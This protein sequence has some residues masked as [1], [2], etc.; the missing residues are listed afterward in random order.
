MMR[1]TLLVAS[2][3]SAF[4]V[5]LADAGLKTPVALDVNVTERWA[6]GSFADTR[7]NPTT[8]QTIGCGL[9]SYPGYTVAYCSAYE[10]YTPETGYQS[11]YCYTTDPAMVDTIKSIANDS[12]IRFQWNGNYGECT[13]IQVESSSNYA[14]KLP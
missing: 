10:G 5:N 12:W 1:R 2:L 4:A 6:E 9:Y 8:H 11:G 13:L 3:A 14:P 7:A